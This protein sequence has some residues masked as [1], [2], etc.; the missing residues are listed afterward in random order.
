MTIPDSIRLPFGA[1]SR[2]LLRDFRACGLCRFPR[3]TSFLAWFAL[4]R[5]FWPRQKGREEGRK[6]R[7][8]DRLTRSPILYWINIVV[9]TYASFPLLSVCVYMIW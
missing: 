4:S 2:Y 7:F 1:T 8:C 6:A 3:R 9:T 5:F